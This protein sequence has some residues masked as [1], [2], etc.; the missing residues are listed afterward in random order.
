V[1]NGCGETFAFMNDRLPCIPLIL[2]W[3]L[4]K[5]NENSYIC[6]IF[7]L[8][9][10]RPIFLMFRELI[11]NWIWLL[12][13]VYNKS[14]FCNQIYAYLQHMHCQKSSQKSTRIIR[15]DSG[16]PASKPVFAHVTA[17]C[18]TLQNT[19]KMSQNKFS[20][21]IISSEICSHVAI[22]EKRITSFFRVEGKVKNQA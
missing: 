8:S 4:G 18:L 2:N 11:M 19:S 13:G 20:W 21:R 10:E 17:S 22:Y 6:R 15:A 12:N 9:E 1:Y 5:F 3:F 16:L 14:I 7:S